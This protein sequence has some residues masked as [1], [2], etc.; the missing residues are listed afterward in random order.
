MGI[1]EQTLTKKRRNTSNSRF[2]FFWV[3]RIYSSPLSL[4]PLYFNYS[5]QIVFLTAASLPHPTF[6]FY[7]DFFPSLKQFK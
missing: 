5:T 2:F 4:F 6:F 3:L 1:R 7:F